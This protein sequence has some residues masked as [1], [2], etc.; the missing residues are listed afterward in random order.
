MVKIIHLTTGEDVLVDDEDYP[1]LSRFTWSKSTNHAN[2]PMARMYREK[3]VPID[4]IMSQIILGG[5]R[6][7]FELMDGNT[8][9]MQKRNLRLLEESELNLLKNKAKVYKGQTPSSRYK[10]VCW[11]KA[12]S[13]WVAMVH[14]NRKRYYLGLFELEEDAALAYNKKA[15][16]LYGKFA[17]L[18][19]IE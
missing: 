8:L 7:T 3:G 18:N 11:S 9:N 10:G 5:S 19:A 16:E 2:Y 17:K 4:V 6:K 1:V 12:S 15:Q 14:M 13:K